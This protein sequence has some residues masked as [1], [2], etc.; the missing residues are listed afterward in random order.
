MELLLNLCWLSLAL[1]AY[2]L[3][4]RGQTSTVQ[5]PH[6]PHLGYVLVLGCMLMLLFPVVSATDDLHAMRPEVEESNP[7]KHLARQSDH[8]PS[9]GINVVGG[10]WALLV[11][12][13]LFSGEF[14]AIGLV[15]S[16]SLAVCAYTRVG[17]DSGRAPPSAYPSVLPLS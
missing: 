5:S 14:R 1:P 4:R 9:T 8:H 10:P 12:D 2:W 7:S 16:R 17:L 15:S 6:F 3:W 11:L 13:S